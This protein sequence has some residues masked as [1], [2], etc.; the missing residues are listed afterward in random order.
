MSSCLV[1]AD[2]QLPLSASDLLNAEARFLKLSQAEIERA[3]TVT[4]LTAELL[5]TNI[6]I[7]SGGQFQKILIAAAL[8]GRPN[9]ILFDEPT[10]SLDELTEERIYELLNRIKEEQGIT[11]VLVSH[12]LSVVYRHATMVLCIGKGKPC[13]GP[14]KEVLTPEALE[15]LYSAPPE[16]YCP[17][18]VGNGEQRSSVEITE[19][20]YEEGTEAFHSRR[21]NSHPEAA[22]CGH[23]L[24]QRETEKRRSPL[25][26]IP[27]FGRGFSRHGVELGRSE[28]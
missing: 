24:A 9:V 11:V 26:S 17:A 8:L 21:K 16:L 20:T 2:R 10:A 3:S 7:L 13:F 12:D 6:G 5:S 22:S 25:V 18:S 19:R 23:V 28:L 1:A 14:P 15:A 27:P 4:N